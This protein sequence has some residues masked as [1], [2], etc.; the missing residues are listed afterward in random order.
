MPAILTHDFFG[1]DALDVLSQHTDAHTLDECDAFLLGNQGPDPLFFLAIHPSLHAWRKLGSRMHKEHTSEL[2]CALSG[3]TGV[4]KEHEQAIGRAYAQGFLCHYALDSSAHPLV[5]SRTFA[6]C[7]AGIEGL[8]RTNTREVHAEIEREIDEMALTKKRNQTVRDYPA[9]EN[10]LDA[11]PEVLAIVQKMYTY[12]ALTVY[13]EQI[14]ENLFA[15][16][17]ECYR[18]TLGALHSPRGIKRALIMA[19]EERVRAYSFFGAMAHKV[20]LVDESWYAN[21]QHESWVN[22]YTGKVHTT[23]FWDLYHGA[24]DFAA[25]AITHFENSKFSLEDARAI[26]H[27]INF[28]GEP[29][30]PLLTVED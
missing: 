26:T 30:V 5:Y 12:L 19:A 14:P 29:L 20:H 15:T 18:I 8:S 24:L 1:R 21:S 9:V 10:T 25:D 6:L 11:S 27:E 4:L 17:V 3:A 28:S 13:G 22:P 16:A 2:I 7:D 23:S